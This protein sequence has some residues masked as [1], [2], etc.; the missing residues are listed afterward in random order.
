MSSGLARI[1][2]WNGALDIL[3]EAPLASTSDTGAVAL[4][5]S[6]NYGQAR[7][8]MLGRYYWKFA[9]K[10]ASIAADATSPEWGWLNR[11]ALPADIIR[12]V[13]PTED[14][15]WNGTPIRYEQEGNY[16][17]CDW[18]G[19][20]RLRWVARIEQEG[21]WS[22]DFCQ[23]MQQRLA[24]GMAHWLTGKQSM[25]SELK[26]TLKE[27]LAEVKQVA[28]VQVAQ[29]TYYDTDILLQRIDY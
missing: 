21:L 7:D 26:D 1:D 27:T 16:L 3:H 15:E 25:V 23:V 4:W 5:L 11:Y 6:R 8:F 19:A 20:L 17:L 12:L 22:N 9:M 2:I 14:G 13:P 28:A 10:R 24:L 18:T 29:E